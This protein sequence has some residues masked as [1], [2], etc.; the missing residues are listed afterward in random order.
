MMLPEDY[1]HNMVASLRVP[2]RGL[3]EQLASILYIIQQRPF[4]KQGWRAEGVGGICV[5]LSECVDDLPTHSTKTLDPLTVLYNFFSRNDGDI[6]VFFNMLHAIRKGAGDSLSNKHK[7]DLDY[8]I[9]I[10]SCLRGKV[11]GRYESENGMYKIDLGHNASEVQAVKS[12]LQNQVKD[13]ISSIGMRY[14]RRF[15]HIDQ[16][17]LVHAYQALQKY[18][19]VAAVA[20][21]L[22]A[23]GLLWG[24]ALGSHIVLF[25]AISSLLFLSFAVMSVYEVLF[26]YSESKLSG[27][28][29]Q[30]IE[31]IELTV[32][33]YSLQDSCQESSYKSM[34]SDVSVTEMDFMIGQE[35]VKPLEPCSIE[36]TCS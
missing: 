19:S 27:Y 12:R 13:F 21:V 9:Q 3:G 35:P 4:V 7:Q 28:V 1:M 34:L 8:S 15:R 23:I 5:E 14:K 10:I 18:K 11:V 25:S 26:D 32:A 6:D 20:Y 24:H 30:G 16:Q 36:Q 2:G 22:L 33:E 29:A 31:S 17:W